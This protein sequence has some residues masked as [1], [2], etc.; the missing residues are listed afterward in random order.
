M[1]LASFF[2]F[3]ASWRGEGGYG[4]LFPLRALISSS[5][6]DGR[7]GNPGVKANKRTKDEKKLSEKRTVRQTFAGH[8]AWAD[9]YSLFVFFLFLYLGLVFLR[10]SSDDAVIDSCGRPFPSFFFRLFPSVPNEKV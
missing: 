5:S 6:E 8:L 7:I 10:V 4:S 2:P 1:A 3:R 9:S